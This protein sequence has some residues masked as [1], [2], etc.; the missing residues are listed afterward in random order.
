[1]LRN[2]GAA[3]RSG[4]VAQANAELA[5]INIAGDRADPSFDPADK[6][7]LDSALLFP[8]A[9]VRARGTPATAAYLE[10]ARK[11]GALGDSASRVPGMPEATRARVDSVLADALGLKLIP[12]TSPASG[13]GCRRV[14]A[15]RASGV[16]ATLPRGGAMLEALRAG[17]VAVRRFAS[18]SVPVGGLLPGRPAELRVPADSDPVPWRVVTSATPLRICPLR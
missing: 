10:A 15:G 2:D 5:A 1:M 17:A 18:A 14:G 16:T 7:G 11:Y 12:S 9:E 13:P 3:Y 8:F 4:Y 6:L